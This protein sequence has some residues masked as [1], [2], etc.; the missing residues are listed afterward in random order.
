MQLQEISPLLALPKTGQT[1]SYRNGDDSELQTGQNRPTTRFVLYG[2][3]TARDGQTRLTWIS[4]PE[5]I[6]PGGPIGGVNEVLSA[7]GQ[8]ASDHG[9]Y[10]IGDLVQGDGDPDVLFYVTISDHTASAAN[11]PPNAGMWVV[12][13]WTSSSSDLTS[14]ARMN[15]NDAMDNSTGS[16]LDGAGLSTAGHADWYLPNI[17]EL[18]SIWEAERDAPMLDSDIFPNTQD[19]Y[20]SSTTRKSASN[21]A[22]LMNFATS[23]VLGNLTKAGIVFVRPVRGGVRRA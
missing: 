3:N 2:N 8:W 1:T 12:T 16:D 13:P 23:G 4:Q 17:K 6:L 21:F 20:W 15:W 9:A 14:P 18:Y 7:E 22:K 5:L 11:Q 10:S 19:Q